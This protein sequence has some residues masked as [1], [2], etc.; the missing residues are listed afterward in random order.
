MNKKELAIILSKLKTFEKPNPKLEQY[1]T[2]SEVAAH[3][4]WIAYLNYDIED[5]VIAD[6]G[7]GNGIFGIAALILGAKQVY[8]LDQDESAIKIAKDNLESIES[9]L[10]TKFKAIFLH[11]SIKDIDIKVDTVL[12]N[13]PFGVQKEHA[14]KP[15][16]EK[17]M[18]IANCIYTIHKIESQQFIYRLASLNDFRIERV[19]EF[20]FQ[21]KKQLD[22]HK[23]KLYTV[24]TACWQ[25]KR[26]M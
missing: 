25:L 12:E 16:L 8:F 19:I 21:I 4:T 10:N 6:L 9:E 23:R 13:P 11:E 26:N 3:L 15:F 14:D 20:N 1:Q 2:D 7:C 17:A 22:F 18:K 5:K 24:K